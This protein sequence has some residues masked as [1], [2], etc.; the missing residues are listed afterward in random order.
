MA[1]FCRV[2]IE[3]ITRKTR[4]KK[5]INHLTSPYYLNQLSR[6]PESWVI[7]VDALCVCWDVLLVDK[8]H[9]NGASNGRRRGARTARQGPKLWRATG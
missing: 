4:V 6:D 2:S 9:G 5:R 7:K 8:C 1:Q 3:A